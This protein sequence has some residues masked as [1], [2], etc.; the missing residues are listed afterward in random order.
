MKLVP[1]KKAAVGAVV[2][3]EGVVAAAVGADGVAMVE[4]AVV[5]VA[6]GA[7]VAGIAAVVVAAVGVTVF[8]DN[9]PISTAHWGNGVLL[10]RVVNLFHD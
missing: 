6:T 9:S 4:G 5:V 1:A 3:E 8:A 10:Q 7:A 2:V